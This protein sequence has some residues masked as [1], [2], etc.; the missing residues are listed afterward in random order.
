MKLRVSLMDNFDD[1]PDLVPETADTDADGRYVFPRLWT[2]LKPFIS[3]TA[4]GY[5]REMKR[6]VKLAPNKTEQLSF[7]LTQPGH[8]V[9]GVV[10]DISGHAVEGANIHF[11]GDNQPGFYNNTKTDA[12]GTFQIGPLVS[13]QVYVRVFQETADFSREMD[14]FI[15][16]PSNELRLVLPNADGKVAGTVLDHAGRPVADA[17]VS[18]GLLRRKTH[19]DAQGRFELTGLVKGWFHI[20][21]SARNAQAQ[22]LQYGTRVQT[23]STA[24]QLRMPEH[25]PEHLVLPE[26][27]L[28]LTGQ[29]A[30]PLQVET[31]INSSPLAAKAGGKVRIIDFWGLQCGPCLANLPKIASFWQEHQHEALEIMAHCH[32]PVEEVREFLAKHPDYTFPISIAGDGTPYWR[33]YD[34]RGVPTYV[35][36][37]RSGKIVSYGHDWQAAATAALVEM[38][39]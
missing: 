4:E 21:A 17:E 23:G 8:M 36:T 31:W 7:T 13:G 6:E 39:K 32:Y 29:T 3:C 22:E 12:R 15:T 11:S 1:I 19:T 2:S 9:K 26:E 30:P 20:T 16:V 35:V 25:P 38:K 27:P 37:D 14:E 10:V 34:I 28:N 33:D 24:L 18:A 5:N